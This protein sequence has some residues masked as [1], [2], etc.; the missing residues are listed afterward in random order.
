MEL[1]NAKLDRIVD[2][3]PF[4]LPIDFLLPEA[5]LAEIRSEAAMLSPHHVDFEAGTILLGVQSFVLQVKG[6]NILIDSCIGEDKERP[7]RLDWHRRTGTGYLEALA[8]AGLRPEDIHV[9][10]C[11][12]LHADHVG[13]NTRLDNG[14]WVPTFPRARYMTGSRELAHWQDEERI[15]PGTHNH[16]A[17]TD[18]VLPVIEAGQMEMVDDGF[19]LVGGLSMVPLPGHSP[20]QIGLDLSFGVDEHVLFCGDAIHSPVQ[21]Y[22]PLWSSRFCSDPVEASE[23]RTRLLERSADDGTILVPSHIRHANGLQAKR[24]GCGFRPVFV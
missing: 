19:E 14:R 8:A 15:A 10:L 9:V 20:G 11:T 23:T 13:W 2:L 5:K 3:D 24:C 22:K 21:V 16:G 17:Y 6:L 4:A 18:S 1:G 7:R 12:H